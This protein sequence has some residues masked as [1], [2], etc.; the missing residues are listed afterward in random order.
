MFLLCCKVVTECGCNYIKDT[1]HFEERYTRLF[2]GVYTFE[3]EERMYTYLVVVEYT[4]EEENILLEEGC[5]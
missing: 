3:G 1:I 2:E 5:C 4:F